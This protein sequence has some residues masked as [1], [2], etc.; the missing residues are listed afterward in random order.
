VFFAGSWS[1]FV[2]G[3]GLLDLRGRFGFGSAELGEGRAREV[4]VRGQRDGEL[5]A[6]LEQF[7][8]VLACTGFVGVGD[9][10]AG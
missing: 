9:R 3:D 6:E 7:V 5:A 4:V 10:L 8:G 2:Q 1:G